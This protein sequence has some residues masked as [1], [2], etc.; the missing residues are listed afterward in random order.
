MCSILFTTKEVKDKSVTRLLELRGPDDTTT[1]VYGGYTFVHNLLSL[2]G[3]ITNQPIERNGIIAM[4]NGEIYNYLDI[5]DKS[6][7]DIF[8]IISAY[9]KYIITLFYST[10]AMSNNNNCNIFSYILNCLH[11]ALLC[12]IVK[13]TSSFV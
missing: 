7:S 5:D 4:H 11:N 9:E 13:C 2:T 3:N 1:K 6:T 8:S 12:Q 10:Y